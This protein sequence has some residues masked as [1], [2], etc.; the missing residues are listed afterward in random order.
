MGLKGSPQDTVDSPQ[1]CWTCV[2][3][4]GLLQYKSGNISLG[5]QG[6]GTEVGKWFTFQ[7]Y[8]KQ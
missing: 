6:L 8:Y 7:R 4:L 2:D 3:A 1:Q 5:H